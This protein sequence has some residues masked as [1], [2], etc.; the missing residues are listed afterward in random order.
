MHA[1]RDLARKIAFSHR[2]SNFRD[3]ANLIGQVRGHG[4][5]GIGQ[6]LPG[7]RHAGHHRLAAQLSF[8]TNFAGHARHFARKRIELV[9]HRVHDAGGPDELALQRTALDFQRHFLRQVALRHRSDH[10][11]NL[12]GRLDQI[13][14][15]AVHR[16]H[17]GGPAPGAGVQRGALADSAFF[18]D[19]RAHARELGGHVFVQLKDVVQDIRNLPGHAHLVDRQPNREIAFLEGKERRQNLVGIQNIPQPGPAAWVLL[20]CSA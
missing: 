12:G 19:R 10:A 18:A 1:D 9:H 13:G 3:V 17:A 14:N 15:Q 6:I 16:F 2:R 4:I 7:A 8:R 5:D 20:T 11:G